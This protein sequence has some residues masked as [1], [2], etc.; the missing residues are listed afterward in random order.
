MPSSRNRA[1]RVAFVCVTLVAGATRTLWAQGAEEAL[2]SAGTEAELEAELAAEDAASSRALAKPVEQ[3]KGAIV[4]TVT[5]AKFHEPIVEA[6]VAVIGATNRGFT[7]LNGRFRLELP[8]GAY[9]LRVTFELHRPARVA[10]VVVEPGR[11]TTLD[12][13]LLPDESAVESIQVES[14]VDQASVE[15]QA[16]RR[17]RDA[18]VG[19]SV[20]RAEI[21]RTPD[22]NAAEAA[23]RVVGASVVAGRYVYVRGLGER[24][25][26]ASLNGAPLPSPEPDRNTVPLDLFPALVLESLTIN[27]TFTPDQPADFAG[28]S[29]RLATRRFPSERLVQLSL[30]AGFNTRTTLRQGLG[31]TGS[32][33]DF[34]GF[35]SGLRQLPGGVPG[36]VVVTGASKPDGGTVSAEET[37]EVSRRLSSRMS[38]RRQLMP[39]N[40]GGSLVLGDAWKVGGARKL[41]AL[42][43]LSYSRS[44]Q[45]TRGEIVR[46]YGLPT[47]DRQ[48]LRPLV[49]YRAER[50]VDSVRWG[51]FATVSYE[52][53]GQD[54]LSLDGM[55]S[56]SADDSAAE[57]EGRA[58]S[59]SAQVH[60]T[61][62]GYASRA[63]SFGQLRGEHELPKLMGARLDWYASLSHATRNEPDTRA[64]LYQLRTDLE[65]VAWQWQ[66][67]AQSGS[68]LFADQAEHQRGVGVD[69]TQPL[70]V[71]ERAPKLK[72]GGAL[73]SRERDFGARRFELAKGRTT[74]E[75]EARFFRCPGAV[76]SLDCS[77]RL[78][79]TSSV[80]TLLTG[81]E[82]T[83]ENDAYRASLAVYA[84]YAQVDVEPIQRLRLVAGSRVEVTRERIESYDPFAVEKTPISG[85]IAQTDWLPAL[86]MVYRATP[87]V[88]TRFAL[89]RTLA[90]PQLR[91]LAPFVL[92]PY[93]GGLSTQGNPGLRMTHVTNLDLRVE[94]FP[95][96]REVLAFSIF[97]KHFQDP[98]EEVLKSRGGLYVSYDNARGADLIGMELEGRRGLGTVARALSDFSLLANV[99]L[100]K[101]RVELATLGASTNPSRPLSHQAPYMVN[102][103][104]DYASP[105]ART[106]LRLL[107]NVSGARIVQVGADGLQ[108]I[109]ERPRHL[110]D[111]TALQALGSHF[112]LKLAALNLLDSPVRLTQS[113]VDPDGPGGAKPAEFTTGEYRT[114]TTFS[115]SLAYT[116]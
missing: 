88:N 23:R 96:L 70:G 95:S 58:E 36:Y 68:H 33:T 10:R 92:N 53:S 22:R 11:L 93:F 43:A 87:S 106:Q 47:G 28:G 86:S 61:R 60:A 55:H 57:L 112:E 108:D 41:G 48:E 111:F 62:L 85:S 19:D 13:S 98:I 51:A 38:T 81:S 32:A 59:V 37:A 94:H 89:S 73:S 3:G 9:D 6:S 17:K 45:S 109:F 114:G 97:Y 72:V 52:V 56:Q 35:D 113:G 75:Q 4:G 34:L 15:G 29:V 84:A 16:L 31:Y 54:R 107:Y 67:G 71:A 65:P 115:L 105:T 49:D 12:F 2:E 77:D 1:G 39:P 8:P 20:G 27:K 103:A 42:A 79:Q 30:N 21:A 69:Y 83:R 101:S 91:E 80:G 7:D 26:N 78:F 76:F 116:R 14:E 102:L 90:R 66:A 5:D 40:H 74:P 24:Y 110:L 63:L 64:N 46:V 18:A 100:V 50:G 82:K 44:F 99:T 104:L 25:T